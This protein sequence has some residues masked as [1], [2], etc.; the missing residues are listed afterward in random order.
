MKQVVTQRLNIIYWILSTVG[1]WA[2]CEQ[3]QQDLYVHIVLSFNCK[4]SEGLGR[5]DSLPYRH[6]P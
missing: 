3:K 1:L 6:T 2:P 5:P 4:Y